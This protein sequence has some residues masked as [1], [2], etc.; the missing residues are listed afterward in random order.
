MAVQSGEIGQVWKTTF[1]AVGDPSQVKS[2]L[3]TRFFPCLLLL[4]DHLFYALLPASVEWQKGGNRPDRMDIFE[5]RV[6]CA[7]PLY[8]MT[9][10]GNR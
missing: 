3:R 7:D 10:V 9:E 1:L 4:P 6:K 2:W 5:V 8:R